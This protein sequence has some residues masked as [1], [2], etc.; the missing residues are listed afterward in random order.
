M[1]DPFDVDLA[2]LKA[3]ISDLTKNNTTVIVREGLEVRPRFDADPVIVSD[4]QNYELNEIPHAVQA[5]LIQR[6]NQHEKAARNLRAAKYLD[7]NTNPLIKLES[8]D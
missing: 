1:S 7:P 3:G 5:E 4:G 2:I 6:F 8:I